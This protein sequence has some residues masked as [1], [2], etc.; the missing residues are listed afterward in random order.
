MTPWPVVLATVLLGALLLASTVGTPST[1]T[2]GS[3]D[4]VLWGG[5]EGLPHTGTLVLTPETP[6]PTTHG[7]AAAR[8]FLERGGLVVVT[9]WSESTAAFVHWLD[10]GMEIGPALV[11]DPDADERGMFQVQATGAGGLSG[12]W[13]VSHARVVSGSGEALLS[14]GPFVWSDVGA[15]GRPDLTDPRGPVA[16]ARR[17]DVGAGELWVFGSGELLDDR[18][19]IT[20]AELQHDRGPLVV[21]VSSTSGLDALGAR[22]F[23]AGEHAAWVWAALVGPGLLGALQAMRVQL[24]RVRPRRRRSPLDLQTLEILAELPTDRGAG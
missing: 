21:T 3:P 18:M 16:V 7:A 13:M 5:L 20:L 22:S 1:T 11:F 19:Q 4:H 14:T 10:V 12:S 24:R 15:D 23:F 6:P 9:E 2:L 17:L 8:Q